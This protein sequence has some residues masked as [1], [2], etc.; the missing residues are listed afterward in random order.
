M[1]TQCDQCGIWFESSDP[2][3][4]PMYCEECEDYAEFM[5]FYDLPAYRKVPNLDE[6]N[7]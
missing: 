4:I 5:R 6:E 1:I 7:Q 2:C 3:S